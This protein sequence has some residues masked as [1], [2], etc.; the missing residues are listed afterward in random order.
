MIRPATTIDFFDSSE[1]W[2]EERWRRHQWRRLR[3]TL[4]TAYE[5]LPFYRRRFDAAGLTPLDIRRPEDLALVPFLRKAD[6]VRAMGGSESF[7]VGMEAEAGAGPRVLAMTS[8]TVATG[9]LRLSSEWRRT[10]GKAICRAYWWAGARPGMRI[11]AAAPAW[12]ATAIKESWAIERL[13]GVAVVPRGTF[14]PHFASEYLAVLLELR[15]QFAHFF[16][17]MLYALLAECRRRA[18]DPAEVFGSFETVAVGGAPMTPRAREH[19]RAELGVRDLFEGAGSAEGL[20]AMECSAHQGHHVFVDVCHVEVVDPESGQVLPPG[21]RGT[22]VLTTLVPSGSIY[23]RYDTEDIGEILPGRCP[24]GRTWPRL[25][26]YDRRANV[27]RVQGRSLLWYDVRACLDEMPDLI[28][29]PC[30]I[31]RPGH[32]GQVLRIAVEGP[33]PHVSASLL[34]ELE[35][36]VAERL[37]VPVSAEWV[38]A[39]PA[40]WKGVAV[41]DEAHWE[42]YRG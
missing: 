24:C 15:P 20:V 22:V 17:P 37:N 29:V 36:I 35:R 7:A 8:G 16:L 42:V 3:R 30:V 31:V 39:L 19:L 38:H 2:S 14:V 25:E 6:V 34:T 21:Q 4:E 1:A 11:L 27:V 26:L 40:R 13:G 28:G 12:H 10:M 41:I 18:I 9:V 32:D 5:R 33:P 23:I